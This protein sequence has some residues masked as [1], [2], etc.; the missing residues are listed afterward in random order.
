MVRNHAAGHAVD[1]DLC[2]FVEVLN[3]KREN[4]RFEIE[5]DLQNVLASSGF[6]R[7]RKCVAE[8]EHCFA[9][10][11]ENRLKVREIAL[12]WRIDG[13]SRGRCQFDFVDFEQRQARPHIELVARKASGCKLMIWRDPRH[14]TLSHAGCERVC[15]AAVLSDALPIIFDPASGGCAAS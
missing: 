2:D 12:V 5:R 10:A 8:I 15:P 11:R 14:V 6:I 1:V 7:D 9:Q 4:A 3:L 13:G